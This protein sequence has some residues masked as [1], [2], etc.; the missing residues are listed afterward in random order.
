MSRTGLVEA[1][2]AGLL[3][4][5]TASVAAAHCC[6]DSSMLGV[7]HQSQFR[8]GLHGMGEGL[9]DEAIEAEPP[10]V[11]ESLTDRGTANEGIGG[12]GQM[13]G[14]SVG[15]YGAGSLGQA[16]PGGLG[17]MRNGGLGSRPVQPR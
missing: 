17:A 2:V 8:R 1:V 9:T 10:A 5:A 13:R 16:G 12:L 14:N 3:L 6:H 4:A 15:N 11:E 7:A